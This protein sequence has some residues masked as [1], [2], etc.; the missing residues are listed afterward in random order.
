MERP[1]RYLRSQIPLLFAVAWASSAALAGGLRVT[2]LADAVV[3]GD[4]ILLAN[5]LPENA[6]HA[7]R[8]A[9]ESISLGAAPQNGTARLFRRD[10]IL[11]ALKSATLSPA[12]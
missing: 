9:A 8:T 10:A 1:M 12:S 3:Q 6:S 11:A 2:L 5:L 4:T 7:L